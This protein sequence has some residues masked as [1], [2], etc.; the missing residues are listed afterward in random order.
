M[1]LSCTSVNDAL[2]TSWRCAGV[3]RGM[4]TTPQ[5][6]GSVGFETLRTVEPTK[7]TEPLTDTGSRDG[8]PAG[9]LLTAATTG[10]SF[11][12]LGARTGELVPATTPDAPRARG[13]G[14]GAGG[15]GGAGGAGVP[16]GIDGSPRAA[17]PDKAGPTA[18][19]AE[20]S[21]VNEVVGTVAAPAAL[22]NMEE[23]ARATIIPPKQAAIS[24]TART[25]RNRRPAGVAPDTLPHAPLNLTTSDL[26][27]TE[28][29]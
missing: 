28:G 24:I 23:R 20:G 7:P 26:P 4:E 5:V 19:E 8:T 16:V 18:P 29:G 6:A 1:T 11:R 27:T 13:G 22:G 9:V 15:V 2:P 10:A 14:D 3:F 12:V 25:G 21:A 17:G